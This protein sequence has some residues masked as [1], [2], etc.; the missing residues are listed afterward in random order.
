VTSKSADI[1]DLTGF[2]VEVIRQSG[3]VALRSYGKGKPDVKFDDDLVTDAELI[4]TDHFQGHLKAQFPD[5]LLFKYDQ[6]NKGY[7][8]EGER[9]LWIFDPLDGVANFQAGIPIWGI[10]L[11]LL[12]NFWPIFGLFYMPVTGDLFHARA[13]HTAFRGEEEIHISSQGSINDESLLLTY[14][15]FHQYYHSAFPGKIRDLG[16][17]SAHV[18]YVAMGRAEA[19]I[20]ARE[21]YQNLAAAQVIAEAAGAKIFKMDGSEFSLGDYL[22][23]ARIDDHLLVVGAD[24]HSQIL[25]YLQEIT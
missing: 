19:A 24:L 3:Q 20:I 1:E 15:R 9:Y 13:G 12:D 11:A 4:L 18:C 5:H 10:S 6:R 8:H 22:D 23:G 21:S 17:T 7:S 16:C 25:G 14:S 2:A